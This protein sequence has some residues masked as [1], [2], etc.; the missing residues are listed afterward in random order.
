[1]DMFHG[2]RDAALNLQK[3]T[4]VRAVILQGRGSA[5][6][7]GLDVK[8]VTSN[9]MNMAKLLKR[10]EG[11]LTNLAQDVA[12]LWRTLPCPVIASTHGICFGGGLQIVL[13]ADFRITTPD[14][15]FSIMEAKW[16]LIPDMSGS[17][18]LREL[19]TIDVA[20][21]LSMTA[22]VFDGS[23]AK[24]YGLVSHVAADPFQEAMALAK[25][26]GAR[27]PDSVA[28]TKQ[29]FNTTWSQPE[30]VALE[31]ETEL[32]KVLLVPPLKNTMAAASQGM[33]LPIQLDFKDRQS[34]WKGAEQ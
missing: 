17:V 31:A 5:F 4:S 2:I 26:I 6:S 32:Q 10:P 15:K 19:V 7:S 1:M 8:S 13:G 28:A 33:N 18:L 20:K 22:R 24:E 3:D 30:R 23:Q 14:C 27:S 25:E 11:K 21:E 34:T 29:L 9:P 12:W 16:G